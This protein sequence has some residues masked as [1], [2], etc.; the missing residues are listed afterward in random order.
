VIF[1]LAH[2]RKF[3]GGTI[4]LIVGPW[5]FKTG[6]FAFLFGQIFVLRTPNFQGASI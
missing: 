6:I 4:S 5:K 3:S 2:G 1:E